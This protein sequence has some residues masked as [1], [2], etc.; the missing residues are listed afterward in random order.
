MKNFLNLFFGLACFVYAASLVP[1]LA[2]DEQNDAPFRLQF[3]PADCVSVVDV[4]KKTKYGLGDEIIICVFNPSPCSLC[5]YVLEE[6]PGRVSLLF[7]NAKENALLGPKEKRFISRRV[8]RN[9]PCGIVKISAVGLRVEAERYV[10]DAANPPNNSDLLRGIDAAFRYGRVGLTNYD[11]AYFWIDYP[12]T[13]TVLET[14][15]A[16]PSAT[17]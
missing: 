16:S 9:A 14:I 7:P 10:S 17:K 15:E 13:A 1:V 11:R 6:S 8:T 2:D 4:S 5:L 12:K 3:L